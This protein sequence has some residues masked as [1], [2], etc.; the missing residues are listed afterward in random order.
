MGHANRGGYVM[1]EFKGNR[2]DLFNNPKEFPFRRGDIAVVEV[3]RGQDAGLVRYVY[4]SLLKPLP[5][6]PPFAVIRRAG[7]SDRLRIKSHRA[8]E[9]QAL[10]DG[11]Q[12][13]RRH[14]LPMKLVDAECR[15]DGLKLSLYFTAEGRVDFREL[16]RDLAT[17]F[18]M[19]IDLRQI[20][21]RDELR[22]SDGYGPCGERL[23]CARFLKDFRP[24][25]A[26]MAK[27]Q[28]LMINPSKL[29]GVCGRLKCCLAY[30]YDRYITEPALAGKLPEPLAGE[31]QLESLTQMSDD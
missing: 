28:N 29:S 13:V 2:R 20:G 15:F 8:F 31:E 1:V 24:I 23:C 17:A 22:R 27:M 9:T 14:N 4:A 12:L 7:E 10:T 16:V 30:E 11:R 3:D 6:P 21:A 18:H 5:M 26:P 25:S 19:R